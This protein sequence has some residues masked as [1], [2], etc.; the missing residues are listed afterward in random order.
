M[1]QLDL[2]E[3]DKEQNATMQRT[4]YVPTLGRKQAEIFAL[5]TWEEYWCEYYKKLKRKRKKEGKNAEK[6]T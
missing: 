3:K 4:I 1:I 6:Q 2:F 5:S